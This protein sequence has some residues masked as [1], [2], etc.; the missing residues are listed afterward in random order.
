MGCTKLLLTSALL[1]LTTGLGLV[2]TPEHLRAES[3]TPSVGSGT[4]MELPPPIR[5]Y[6]TTIYDPVRNRMIVFGG[7]NRSH[8]NETWVLSLSGTPTWTQLVTAGTPPSSRS[9]HTAIYDSANDRMIV[10]GGG[11][12]NPTV[13][14]DTWALDLSGMPTWSPLLVTG[15]APK[16]GSHSAVYVPARGSMLVFGGSDGNSLWNDTWELTLSSTPSWSQLAPIG[17]PPSSRAGHAAIYD[18][19]SN[20]MIVQG[21][22]DGFS[23]RSDTWSLSLSATPAWSQI[24]VTGELPALRTGFPIVLDPVRDRIILFGG[25]ASGHVYGDTWTLPLSGPAS[26]SQLSTLHLPPGRANHTAIYDPTTDRVLVFGGS[27]GAVYHGET[28]Q[29]ALSTVADWSPV[30][31]PQANPPAR[32][33]ATAVYDPARDRMVVFGGTN[34]NFYNDTWTLELAGTPA[35]TSPA[36]E[37][38]PPSARYGHSA[39]YDPT[40]DR[41][42]IFGGNDSSPR[43]DTWSLALSGTFGW[44]LLVPDGTPPLP[45]FHH[46][47]IF[48]PVRDRLIVFG[49][50]GA[51]G[52]SHDDLWQ[53]DLGGNGMWSQLAPFG[54]GPSAGIYFQSI[55]DPVRDRMI[56][57]GGSETWALN[58][59]GMLAWQQIPHFGEYPT[60]AAFGHSVIYDPVRDRMVVFG[61]EDTPVDDTAVQHNRIYALALSDPPTWSKLDPCWPPAGRYLHCAIYD[62]LRDRMVVYGGSERNDVWALNL[63][64]SGSTPTMVTLF[65]AERHADGVRVSWQLA[66]ATRLSDV[67]VERAD[68]VAGPWALAATELTT[69]GASNVALDRSVL[70][71]RDYWYRLVAREDGQAVV[72]GTPVSVL[73]SVVHGFKLTRVTPNPGLGPVRIS[74]TLAREAV[75]ELD[76]IDLQGRHVTSLVNGSRKAGAHTVEWTGS[77]GA[78]GIYFLYYR[79]PGGHQVE[80]VV[81]LR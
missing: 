45:R 24:P 23:I 72:I 47:A 49:G 15:L 77:S 56:L 68:V 38:M 36:P 81:R 30:E 5:G 8:R 32:Q 62:P 43:N 25:N 44:S 4:W 71:E 28:W 22:A 11:A 40:R 63:D 67:W 14:D 66:D 79:Y 60:P 54:P 26:W 20:R 19:A 70:A 13:F 69:D 50:Y 6:H 57:F 52:A 27:D 65:T 55:Y 16:R 41:M 1:V 46:T 37:G 18:P 33:S 39:I 64:G 53:L 58:L 2:A 76:V 80:R 10:F 12:D 3:C 7:Y 31:V 42:L 73:G 61:G 75:V 35:W 59:S 34:R 51:G 74:Y 78:S 9:R 21:G 17:S 48:D 29:L